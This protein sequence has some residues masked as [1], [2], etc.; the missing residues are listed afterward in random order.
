MTTRH[1]TGDDPHIESL[2]D[3]Y[4]TPGRGIHWGKVNDA[5]RT[6]YNRSEGF[7]VGDETDTPETAVEAEDWR[8]IA[9]EP[10]RGTVLAC[11]SRALYAIGDAHGA[12]ACEL[13]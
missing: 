3:A 4:K 2:L 11:D 10:G 8:L 9:V 12:Y 1:Y 6:V 13:P 5:Y 7:A